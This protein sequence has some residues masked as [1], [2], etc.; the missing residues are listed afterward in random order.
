MINIFDFELSQE[1]MDMIA[2]FYVNKIKELY[3]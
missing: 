3:F 1:D 2:T